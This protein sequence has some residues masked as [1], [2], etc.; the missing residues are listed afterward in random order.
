MLQILESS[1]P[2][3]RDARFKISYDGDYIGFVYLL[4]EGIWENTAHWAKRQFANRE[5]AILDLISQKKVVRL[6]VVSD[7]LEGI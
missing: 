7:I 1:T 4:D 3:T 6:N 2:G 5:S